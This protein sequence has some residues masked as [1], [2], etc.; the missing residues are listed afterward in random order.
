MSEIEVGE[1]IRTEKGLIAKTIGFDDD[2]NFLL[3]N[4]QIITKIESKKIKHSKN[5]IDLI[6]TE[7]IVVLEYYVAKY[8]RRITRKFEIFKAGNLISF[9][10]PH[11]GFLYDVINQKW[12]EEDGFNIKIKE[13]LTKEYFSANSYK[14]GE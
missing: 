11:C 10:N 9:D 8:K 5:I 4:Q 3:D 2:N 6:E 13:I 14:V 7:D 12:C 1:Y